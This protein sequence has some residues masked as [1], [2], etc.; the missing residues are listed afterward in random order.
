[1]V[2][3]MN[4]DRPATPDERKLD[5]MSLRG[6]AHP[7]RIALFDALSVHGPATAT[8]LAARL[9]ESSGATS[10]HLRQ[11]AKH[12]LVHEIEGRGTARERWWERM[13]GSL[14]LDATT[15]ERG[16]AARQ[17]ADMIG[18]E[19]ERERRRLLDEFLRR[20]ADDLDPE[21]IS[22]SRI[23]TSN[24]RLTLEQ[25]AELAELVDRFIDALPADYRGSDDPDARSVQLHVNAFPVLDA[26]PSGAARSGGAAVSGGAALSEES[27]SG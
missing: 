12:R 11:L 13:P 14:T 4:A 8:A 10:Y 16:S 27:R 9:G 22:A 17:A 25:A 6:F 2:E 1:M 23:T 15:F 26:R 3:V 20:G 18:A 7:L 24:L 19:W 5:A 21:W